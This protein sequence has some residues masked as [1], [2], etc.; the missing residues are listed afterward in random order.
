M[1][2]LCSANE[3]TCEARNLTIGILCVR[4]YKIMG[5]KLCI[6]N[7]PCFNLFF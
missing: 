3:Q 6:I 1:A 4:P 5:T 2:A 7:L